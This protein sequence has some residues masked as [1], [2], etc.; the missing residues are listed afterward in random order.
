MRD[1]QSGEP[2]NKLELYEEV[3][4]NLLDSSTDAILSLTCGMDGI[5]ELESVAPLKISP[6]S[7]LRAATDRCLHAV[8]L[9]PKLATFDC[10]LLHLGETIYV[11]R[12]SDLRERWR[13]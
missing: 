5:I 4:K 3:V 7:T 6:R 13:G 8:Q 1:P 10:G 2:S 11:A 9:Q 12:T